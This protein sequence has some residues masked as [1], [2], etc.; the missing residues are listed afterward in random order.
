MP[1]APLATRAQGFTLVELMVAI[2]A[3]M[4]VSIAVFSVAKHASAFATQQAR[5]ADATLQGVI[6]F[7]RLKADI[8]RAGFLSSPNVERDP[9]IC[10]DAGGYPAALAPTKTL[11]A[12]WAPTPCPWPGSAAY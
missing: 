6:G 8:A 2:V 12:T 11:V 3:G 1:R 9:N 5:L 10:R 4:F 7:E